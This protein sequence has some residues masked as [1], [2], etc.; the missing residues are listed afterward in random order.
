MVHAKT[1]K[2]N[3]IDD[4]SDDKENILKKA[5]YI[6]MVWSSDLCIA[7]NIKRKILLRE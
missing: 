7:T 2:E 1:N 6:N 4:K 3:L 5:Y